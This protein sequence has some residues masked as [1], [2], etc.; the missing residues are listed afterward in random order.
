[1]GTGQ[2]LC[3]QS[4]PRYLTNKR[5]RTIT[6][7]HSLVA[8]SCFARHAIIRCARVL[9]RSIGDAQ[10]IYPPKRIYKPRRGINDISVLSNSYY[11]RS[12]SRHE[13]VIWRISAKLIRS[14]ISKTTYGEPGLN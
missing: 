13:A 7:N 11:V 14:A 12:L 3:A 5:P 8:G 1:M 9:N 4:A 10:S 2:A 6:N